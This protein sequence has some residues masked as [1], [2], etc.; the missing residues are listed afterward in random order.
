MTARRGILLWALAA[1][2]SSLLLVGI[3]VWQYEQNEN[4]RVRW[5]VFLAGD[6]QK[7]FELFRAKGCA[8]CHAV[9][10]VGGRLAPDLAFD[11][12]P[13]ADLDQLVTAMW[14]HGPRMWEHMRAEKITY[15]RVNHEEMAHL[16]AYLYTAAYIDEAGDV[17]EGR[18]LFRTKSC[19]RCHD[20][21]YGQGQ[22]IGPNLS[23]VNDI[24]TP[25]AWSHAMWNHAPAMEAKLQEFGLAWP[26][27][28]G[29]EMNDLLAYIRDTSSGPRREFILLPANPEQGRKLFQEKSCQVCHSVAGQGGD[30]GPELGPRQQGKLSIVQFAGLMWNHSS[31]MWR[32]MKAQGIARPTFE[33]QQMADLVAYLYRIRYFES[34]GSHDLGKRLF[35]ERGC[36]GCHG[37]RAQG[38]PRAPT[39]HGGAVA[40]T[41]VTLATAL[42]RHGPRMYERSKDLD[43]S[44]PVL[45][46]NDLQ[47]IMAF[48]NAPP[49]SRAHE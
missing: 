2:G 34:G 19:I 10:G 3:L 41:S 35:A 43:L 33:S 31:E 16:F 30:I 1:L 7:G 49:E 20:F 9:N 23:A 18:R 6:R 15:P 45:Q 46:E 21:Y 25:I 29:R 17:D 24:Q 11:R 39:L 44:W 28:E 38:S 48:L 13:Q 37:S 22:K 42:W 12:P 36:A 47:H 27:F 32:E 4:D 14:N 40:F 26:K 8:Y 5:G